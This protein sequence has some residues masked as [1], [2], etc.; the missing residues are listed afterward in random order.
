M[1]RM[2]RRKK[3]HGHHGGVAPFRLARF[4]NRSHWN[5]DIVS[6]TAEMMPQSNVDA[7][8]TTANLL[9]K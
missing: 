9:R 1:A 4:E 3:E 2:A 6:W 5:S 7:K 8:L